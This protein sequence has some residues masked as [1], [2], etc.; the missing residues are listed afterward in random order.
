MAMEDKTVSIFTYYLKL[1]KHKANW[2][3]ATSMLEIEARVDAMRKCD[4]TESETEQ[5]EMGQV[6]EV[7]IPLHWAKSIGGFLIGSASSVA[8][9]AAAKVNGK[10]GGRPKG[11]GKLQRAAAA[12]AEQA[13]L[14]TLPLNPEVIPVETQVPGELFPETLETVKK[15]KA[16]KK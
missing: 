7:A 16:V 4:P 1:G 8:K 3:V 6:I 5:W 11:S 15:T 10:K 9:Q 2:E 13:K 12:V 14:D